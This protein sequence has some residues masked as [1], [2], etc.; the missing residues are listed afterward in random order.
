[1]ESD[2][3]TEHGAGQGVDRLALAG[4]AEGMGIWRQRGRLVVIAGLP[5]TL[6]RRA[7]RD[8]ALYPVPECGEMHVRGPLV[9]SRPGAGRLKR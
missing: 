3:V 6:R 4:D 1:M 5:L 9:P 8:R 7:Q 2:I